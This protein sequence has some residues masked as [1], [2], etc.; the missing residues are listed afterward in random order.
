MKI[1][2]TQCRQSVSDKICK[3]C[4]KYVLR[5]FVMSGFRQLTP[6]GIP[7]EHCKPVGTEVFRKQVRVMK[8]EL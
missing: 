7:F 2:E 4:K 1:L 8:S 5:N 6:M 3:T